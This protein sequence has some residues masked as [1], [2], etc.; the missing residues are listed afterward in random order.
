MILLLT[1]LG[2]VVSVFTEN[3]SEA[4]TNYFICPGIAILR[5]LHTGSATLPNQSGEY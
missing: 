1:K 5:V 3:A 4:A 2:D